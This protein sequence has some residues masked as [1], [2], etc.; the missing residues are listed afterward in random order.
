MTSNGV[1]LDFLIQSFYDKTTQFNS[2]VFSIDLVII[3]LGMVITF[4]V[5][6]FVWRPFV[7]NLNNNIWRTKG[8]LSMIP[9]QV[10]LENEGLKKAMTNSQLMQSVK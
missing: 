6:L 2:Y 5:S 9:I 1:A 3:I 7:E 10:I 4:A 8:M